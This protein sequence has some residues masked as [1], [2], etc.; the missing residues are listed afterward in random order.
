MGDAVNGDGLTGRDGFVLESNVL[1]KESASGMGVG[2][3]LAND[4][5]RELRCRRILV[6]VVSIAFDVDYGRSEAVRCQIC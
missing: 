6:T 3:A 1:I 2:F 5:E 4:A